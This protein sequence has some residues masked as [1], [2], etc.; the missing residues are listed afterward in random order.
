MQFCS[1]YLSSALVPSGSSS[2]R[3]LISSTFFVHN[4]IRMI[5]S[6]GPISNNT[7]IPYRYNFVCPRNCSWLMFTPVFFYIYIRCL[8]IPQC[9]YPAT[10][11]CLK[12]SYATMWAMYYQ[13]YHT[14]YIKILL[15]VFCFNISFL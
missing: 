2:V 4:Y 1:L 8:Q 6:Y 14:S 5:R 3:R 13:L 15:S 10:L 9:K 12:Y 7:H 11:L